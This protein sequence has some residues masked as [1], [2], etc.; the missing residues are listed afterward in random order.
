ML[1]NHFPH[2]CRLAGIAASFLLEVSML[3]WDAEH[4]A[5]DDGMRGDLRLALVGLLGCGGRSPPHKVS[6]RTADDRKLN[7]AVASCTEQQFR[8]AMSANAVNK[9]MLRCKGTCAFTD[10][11]PW[12]IYADWLGFVTESIKTDFEEGIH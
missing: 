7:P 12:I 3:A 9:E 10:H 5:V 1:L 4:G 11:T 2:T 6:H 8:E